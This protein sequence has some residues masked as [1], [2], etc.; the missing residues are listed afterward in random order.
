MSTP[1]NPESIH[2]PIG[3]YSH[4]VEVRAGSR[5]LAIAGQV[6]RSPDGQVPQDPIE[7]TSV[8][9]ENVRRNLEA[10]G[11]DIKDVVKLNWY[12]VGQMDLARRRE[13]LTAWLGD[14]R[15]ASTL[16]YVAALAAPEYRVEIEAWAAK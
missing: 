4:Q 15:P 6:G 8:A 7:Q 1:R 11:M 2:P 13:V 9:L 3:A 14:H 12:L 16:V 5:L 10:A